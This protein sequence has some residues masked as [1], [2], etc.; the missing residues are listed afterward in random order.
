MGGRG[1]DGAG[2]TLR[3]A[4]RRGAETS[5][6]GGRSHPPPAA[7]CPGTGSSP[8]WECGGVARL[9]QR[10]A[11]VAAGTCSSCGWRAASPPGGRRNLKGR[12]GGKRSR[13]TQGPGGGR[14]SC[15]QACALLSQKLPF[16]GG[17]SCGAGRAPVSCLR[18]F[19]GQSVVKS[20][21]GDHSGVI[22]A[23]L[24]PLR[25]P[26]WLFG[27]QLLLRMPHLAQRAPLPPKPALLPPE[28]S[29]SAPQ[30]TT[31]L[32]RAPC[33]LCPPWAQGAA[34]EGQP[35]WG[36]WGQKSL[37]S[38]SPPKGG[39]PPPTP[40]CLLLPHWPFPTAGFF[41]GTCCPP[42]TS[43]EAK[44]RGRKGGRQ[45]EG[46]A[47]WQPPIPTRGSPSIQRPPGGSGCCWPTSPAP[48]PD[49]SPA[50]PLLTVLGGRGLLEHGLVKIPEGPAQVL[51]VDFGVGELQVAAG[52]VVR[53]GHLAPFTALSARHRGR[54]L[55]RPS[56]LLQ[57][58]SK[59]GG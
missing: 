59:W 29:R 58:T 8:R 28:K 9:R 36:C 4:W 35:V 55:P 40:G 31:R 24:A 2:G 51:E 16:G 39:R 25:L 38:S 32:N 50:P 46:A 7:C 48:S 17:C 11:P 1:D 27:W 12:S 30:P 26:S 53:R 18:P 10:G 52:A 34:S 44:G 15:H 54:H 42:P 57:R 13:G 19:L 14:P 37:P 43:R 22:Q 3:A 47:S 20:P 33:Q 5:R 49:P 21:G 6:E 41:P 23:L 45:S 56:A